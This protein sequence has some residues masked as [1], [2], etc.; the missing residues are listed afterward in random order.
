VSA[1]V[2]NVIVRVYSV[3]WVRLFGP[4]GLPMAVLWPNWPLRAMPE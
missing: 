2:S 4:I 1:G 3:I